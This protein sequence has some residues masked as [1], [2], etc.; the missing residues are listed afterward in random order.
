MQRPPALP[1]RLLPS[2]LARGISAALLGVALTASQP[3]IAWAEALGQHSQS[4]TF[5]VAAGPLSS[6]LAEFASQAGIT[7]PLEPD[8]V[9]GLKSPGFSGKA[10][11]PQALGQL[12]RGTGLQASDQ[13]N[14][15]YLLNRV[16]SGS[17]LE[18]GAT[19]V[20]G[21]GLGLTT[22]GS[23]SYTTGAMSSGTKLSLS[24]RETP[25]S[26]SVISR[27]RMDDQAMTTLGDA[28]KYTPGLTLTKWGGERERFNSRGFQLNNLMIDGIPVQYEEASLSTG[29][30]SMYDRI[31]VV[32][33][34][35]GL[36][37]G[38]GS[39]GGSINLIR[40][41]PTDTFQGSITAGAGS[42]DNYRSELDLSGPLN[43]NGTLRGRT[44]LS[45][46]DKNAFIDDYENQRNLFYGV[47][48]GDLGED[49]TLAIGASWSQ[50][51]N[52]GADWNGRGTYAD[53]H[54]LPISRSTRMSPSWS[55]WDKESTSVF[56]D[57]DHR[58]A[59]GWAAKL[60]A[61][62]IKSEMDMFGT[63]LYRPDP[64]SRDLGFGVGQYH[65]ENTQ[66]SLDGYLTGPFSLFGRSHELV[67]GG[68]YRKQDIDDGPGG[69]P[70]G[71]TYEF[72]PLAFNGK[73][74][75]K[76]Q[77]VN[78]W[79]RDGKVD[80]SSTYVTARFS[81]T[82]A[83]KLAVGGRLDW[84][85]YEVTT[86]SGTWTGNDAYKATREFTPYL[87][88][89][90]DLN[91]NYTAYASWTRIF[92]P[93]NY[94]MASG[95]LLDPQEGSNYEIGLKGEYLDGRL[96]A[97]VALFQIDLENLPMQL[98]SALCPLQPSGCYA[99]SGEVRS[100]GVE[101]ELSGEVLPDWQV[102]AGYTYNYAKHMKASEYA[103]I[104]T[105]S[106]GER[107]ATNLPLNL[108][109][110]ATSYRLPSELNR[111]K[112]GGGLHV[113]SDI[114]SS[115]G[116]EQ[117]GYAVVDLFTSYDVDSHLTLSLNANN[118]FDREYYSSILATSGGNFVGD[119]RNYML[120]ARYRF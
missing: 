71:F 35:A 88:F 61:T 79:S 29:L 117:G 48:E 63:Y 40:K 85:E 18:L 67:V 111:W 3:A 7:L 31:E 75:P 101:L 91:Q 32:R 110:L 83:L 5:Q 24:P 34:A 25:Q 12:L 16:S 95:G 6:A 36:M 43:A 20:T 114:Y 82:D 74:V 55:Y 81:L 4:H 105:T 68:S 64:A 99:A 112:V 45:F 19:T 115:D 90:Y 30:L 77:I 56:A 2:G 96:N 27:Q 97:S 113:Q 21:T 104:G 33:G 49:T 50:D 13:G 46:Q 116:I 119:P 60:A 84:Y 66:T 107:Y 58:F 1:S 37:E 89:T 100:R 98:D 42:W 86:H 78:A 8:L 106:S 94:A 108:F 59:N 28:V 38:A 109:K 44:V 47:L 120:T 57:L 102:S 72:D 14:G 9:Q 53:G 41:R 62:A 65:Y 87:G 23:G 22:E 70:L 15:L 80:Q 54:F 118:L 52:P 73:S 93:Q 26:V 11:V 76:P 69:W 10:S 92:N 51:N 103:P 17:S 39:P